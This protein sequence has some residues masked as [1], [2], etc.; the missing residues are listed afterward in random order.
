M[1]LEAKSDDEAIGKACDKSSFFCGLFKLLGCEIRLAV[2]PF[3]RWEMGDFRVFLRALP[4]M[5]ALIAS[6]RKP[7]VRRNY[8]HS[9]FSDPHPP[10]TQSPPSL[11]PSLNMNLSPQLLLSHRLV[12]FVQVSRVML[13]LV[14]RMTEY[15]FEHPNAVKHIAANCTLLDEEFIEWL[16]A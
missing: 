4:A 16:D 2:E 6:G 13:M 11:P 7:K 15:V 8:K 12:F 3:V 14:E 10:H 5:R 1:F 9:S